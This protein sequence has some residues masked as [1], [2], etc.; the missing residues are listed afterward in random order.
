MTV[1]PCPTCGLP[2]QPGGIA[3]GADRRN[4][5]RHRRICAEKTEAERAAYLRTGLWPRWKKRG[6]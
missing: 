2:P 3:V 1:E 4:M 5:E 6:R